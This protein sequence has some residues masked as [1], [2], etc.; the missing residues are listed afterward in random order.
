[1]D[2]W[3]CIENF[4]NVF[5]ILGIVFIYYQ[6]HLQTKKDK[7]ELIIQLSND[8][9]NN[10]KLQGVFEFLDEDGKKISEINQALEKVIWQGEV[11]KR[12][13]R[14]ENSIKEI[15]FNIYFNFFNSI[16]VLVEEKVVKKE[17][18]MQLFRYQ[19]EKTFCYP[20]MFKYME[21][22]GFEKLKLLLPDELF[23]YGTLSS[24]TDRSKIV[25][26][27]SCANDL[28][29]KEQIVL[30]DFEIVDVHSDQIYKGMIPSKKGGHVL[31]TI[32]KIK[33]K[34]SW[35]ELFSKLDQYEEV[36][37]LYERKIIRINDTRKYV[38]TYLK[39]N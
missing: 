22:F 36:D 35:S 29:N 28:I 9:Y 33:E 8:F 14:N 25:E 18:A 24:P 4:A 38:W 37:T 39:K 26:L 11:I 13:D 12:G 10:D 34:A 21:D 32:L 31:G 16:A 6:I 2:F 15:H 30:S 17:L 1:M 5:T 3:N 27:G 20:I 19:L 7:F 23:T